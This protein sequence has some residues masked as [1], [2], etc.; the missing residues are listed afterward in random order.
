MDDV[1]EARLG[2]SLDDLIK[3]QKKAVV[4]KLPQKKSVPTKA[5]NNATNS[6]V[7]TSTIL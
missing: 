2:M 3:E 6:K 4:K 7:C 1:I 5:G